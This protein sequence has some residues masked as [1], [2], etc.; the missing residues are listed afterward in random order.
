MDD[1]RELIHALACVVRLRIN[2]FSTEMSPLE[3]IDRSQVANFP[4]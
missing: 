3:T 2:I 4:M 1:P